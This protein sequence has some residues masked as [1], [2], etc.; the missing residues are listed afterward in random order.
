MRP[1]ERPQA[2]WHASARMLIFDPRPTAKQ[3]ALEELGASVRKPR[4]LKKGK[5]ALSLGLKDHQLSWLT[6]HVCDRW[7]ALYLSLSAWRSKLAK[8]ERMS[9]DDFSDRISELDQDEEPGKTR[10]IFTKQ[11]HTLGLVAGFADFA[12]AQARDDI[13]GTRPWLAAT[14]EG[15]EDVTL[16]ERVTKHCQWK[17]N[18]SNIE[19]AL[20]DSVRTAVDLGTSF[21]KMRWS[22]EVEVYETVEYVA[23]SRS[24]DQPFLTVAGD[25]V[26]EIADLPPD[27][28]GADVEWREMLV[29]NQVTLADNLST[30]MIDYRDIAFDARAP[31][32]DLIH[33]DVFH[34][35]RAGLL[36]AAALLDL[37]REQV[38]QLRRLG[39]D[40]ESDPAREHRTGEPEADDMLGSLGKEANPTV[41]LIEGFV[42]CDPFANGRPVRLHV[43]FSPEFRMVLRADYLANETPGG[44]LPVFPV[45]SFKLPGR[46]MGRGYW[47]RYEDIQNI[48]D[49]QYNSIT[50]RNRIAAHPIG[51]FHRDA[52]VGRLEGEEVVADMQK[53][54]ELEEGK[55]LGDFVE[56]LNIPDLNGR[57]VELMNQALQMSQMRSGI[58]SAAQGE[59]KGVPQSNTA[60]GVNAI[61]SRG[62]Q[63]V[64]WPINQL[65]RDLTLAVEYAVH[66]LYA[67]QDRD[68]T[69]TWGEGK[70]AELLEIKAGDVRGLR[71]NVTLSL[72]QSQN[73]TKL[74][75]SQAAIQIGQAYV[76]LPETEKQSQRR[77][78]LQAI[79]ALGF[80]DSDRIVR[81]AVVDP[82]GIAA[83]LP[84]ELQQPFLEWL[85]TQQGAQGAD[86]P[87]GPSVSVP[88]SSGQVTDEP[89][90]E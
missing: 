2:V 46:V 67:N 73:Q 43:V 86:A 4:L 62:A 47:E 87:V 48:I 65:V 88:A 27:I 70:D 90:T 76:Q 3:R 41:S 25:Y 77:M 31:E 57:S 8:Y 69:F 56:F 13:F 29:E 9:E 16:A 78:Y 84:T 20:L 44:L 45:R 40:D 23:F 17:F 89:T 21:V 53:L 60:T 42:R 54:Y 63:L 80:E 36:D 72:A 22:K 55:R 33:T 34:R 14:P 32:L 50:F 15:A 30:S 49:G 75:S 61:I 38:D 26:T 66:L 74:Q 64:K 83:M 52:V 18:S 58:T 51:G 5:T 24:G 6:D 85:S 28:D 37:T 68:E 19:G 10:T 82:Q 39:Q 59:L 1:F 12:Y 35:F 11:N 71:A 7:D 79:K 81:D